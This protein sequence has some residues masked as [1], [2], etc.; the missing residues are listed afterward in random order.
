MNSPAEC[1]SAQL[2]KGQIES[3]KQCRAAVIPHLRQMKEQTGDVPLLLTELPAM[4]Q[5]IVQQVKILPAD[6]H[7]KG[8]AFGSQVHQI[9]V[10]QHFGNLYL[11]MSQSKAEG[12]GVGGYFLVP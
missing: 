10:N 4:I 1:L 9:V 6:C 5:H 8:V 12:I 7:V 11:V 2:A 3:V